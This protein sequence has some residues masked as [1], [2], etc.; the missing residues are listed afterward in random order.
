MT[1]K[2]RILLS[3]AWFSLII[4]AGIG[5]VF[6]IQSE[7]L[8]NEE[9]TQ[10]AGV[11]GTGLGCLGGIGFAVLWLPFA[12]RLGKQ[13]REK[14]ERS[15]ASKSRGNRKSGRNSSARGKRRKGKSGARSR[16]RKK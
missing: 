1:I 5:G 4:G 3:I 15:N 9:R 12:Y 6:W 2:K 13:K 14:R 11:L 8:N 10:R 16:G 7:T